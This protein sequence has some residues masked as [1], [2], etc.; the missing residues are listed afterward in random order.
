MSPGCHGNGEEKIAIENYYKMKQPFCHLVFANSWD[1][2]ETF[3]SWTMLDSCFLAFGFEIFSVG[4][5]EVVVE[6]GTSDV[7]E[8]SD[9]AATGVP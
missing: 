9:A 5:E 7:L 1:G 2:L 8:V 4:L 3:Y 6:T